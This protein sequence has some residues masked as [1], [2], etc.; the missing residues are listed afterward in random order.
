[1]AT[2]YVFIALRFAVDPSRHAVPPRN[3]LATAEAGSIL[4]GDG[5]GRMKMQECF[6][7]LRHSCLFLPLRDTRNP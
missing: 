4:Q 3:P 7:P 2:L 1:M 5:L 6:N